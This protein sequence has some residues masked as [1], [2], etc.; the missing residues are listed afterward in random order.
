[1]VWE[2]QLNYHTNLPL[3]FPDV[4]KSNHTCFGH[5]QPIY[6][7]NIIEIIFFHEKKKKKK[8]K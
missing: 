8:K 4:L 2:G 1:M 5:M 7:P 6:Q 3:D